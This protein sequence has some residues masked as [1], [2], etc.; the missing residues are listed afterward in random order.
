MRRVIIIGGGP[1]GSVAGAPPARG[2][3]RVTLAEQ[4]RFP[5]DKVCGECLS[6]LGAEVLGRLGLFDSIRPLGAVRLGRTL[7]HAPSG[8]CAAADLPRPM[9]G[10][11]RVA[12]DGLLLNAAAD[13]GTEVIQPARC[14]A[15]HPGPRPSVILRD[16]VTNELRTVEAD[17]V[18]L[19]DGKSALL[20]GR[21]PR[22]T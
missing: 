11:S 3:W 7:L 16:L 21:P 14:E 12:L 17:V 8:R 18:L 22:P 20:D 4:H 5:R 2:E 15:I 9:W 19:A 1:A 10:V 13:A 6:A